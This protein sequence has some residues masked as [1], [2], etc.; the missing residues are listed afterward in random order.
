[1]SLNTAWMSGPPATKVKIWVRGVD[2]LLLGYFSLTRSFAY[3]GIPPLKLF[4]GELVLGAFL[5][6]QT[7]AVLGRWLAA[8]VVPAPLSG[9]AWGLF[10]FLAYGL[11]QVIRGISLGYPPLTA[12]Q[13]L[14]FNY[15]P[16][17]LFLGLWVGVRMPT[18]LPRFVHLLAWCNG[19]YGVTYL[20]LLNSLPWIIP[21]SP[22]VRLFGQPGGSAVALLGLLIFEHRLVRVW[23]LLLLNGF[24]MLGLQVR[25]EW[26]GFLV[27]VAL[28]GWLT[29]RLDRLGG[30][31]VAVGILLG[32]MLLTD[33]KLP[34]VFGRGGTISVQEMVGRAVAPLNQELAAQYTESAHSYAG[35]VSWRTEWWK[36][37]WNSIHDKREQTL[38]GY[39]YGKA[40]GDLVPYLQG[41]VIRTP[42]N[43]FFYALA[44]GG[45]VGV[46]VFFLFQW[47]VA[48]LL[49]QAYRVTGQ[50]V[51]LVFW[52]MALTEGFFS[53]FFETPF[54]AIPF[55][56]LVGLASAPAS[57][58]F[59]VGYTVT[60]QGVGAASS[61]NEPTQ[62]R[63][64]ARTTREQPS[65]IHT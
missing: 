29:K 12:V 48:R 51:G 39:G 36:A 42:H 22:E 52:A 64:S 31:G 38:I 50:P 24:V 27:A 35:T 56:L 58:V 61:I 40:L 9:V 5:L 37:I 21:G 46:G 13:N 15:Y 28:W 45:W 18:Y 23:T 60:R 55:Y 49:W 63:R 53:N 20:V 16:L 43:V 11:F 30:V 17:Y 65:V 59:A 7:R 10:L 41:D 44:Y 25:A 62:D 33:L 57:G 26:L 14:V 8:L 34:G 32:V 54:G 3:V 4:I 6:S 19:I 1:M 2:L 47:T